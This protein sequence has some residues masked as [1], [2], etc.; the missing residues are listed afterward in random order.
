MDMRDFRRS[1]VFALLVLLVCCLA[2]ASCSSTKP[3]G[4]RQDPSSNELTGFWRPYLLYALVSPHPRLYVEV[5]AVEGCIPD[6]AKLNKL[7]DFLTTYCEKP[8]G[9]DIVRSDVIPRAAAQGIPARALARRFLNGPPENAAAPSPA[10]MYVLFYDQG[11]SDKTVP[12]T[13]QAHAKTPRHKRGLNKNP[14]VDLLPY[15][16]AIFINTRYGPKSVRNELL[17]HEAG[18]VLGVAGRPIYA[19][20]YHCLDRS[21]LMYKT[22]YVHIGR[23][24]LGRDPMTQRQIC[25]RCVAE[26]T[27]SQQQPA[28][29]KLR[30]V[31]PVLVRSE[32]GYH[33]LSLPFRVKLIVGDL[34]E[35]DCR[36]FAAAVRAEAPAPG[37][38]D[39]EFRVAGLVKEELFREPANDEVI[40]RAK[41][42]P[43]EAVRVA[44]PRIWA[45]SWAQR[46]YAH[47][48]FTN[49]VDI[50]RQ[51]TASNPKDDWSFNQLAWIRATC[52]DAS[53]RNGQEAV[54]AATKACE[55]TK[56]KDGNL[57]DTLAAACAESGDFKGAIRFEEQ[58][59]RTGNPTESDRKDMQARLSLYKQS[60][61]FREGK[62][63]DR[64]L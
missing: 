30:F 3:R 12:Q 18:H 10:F 9:I 13:A 39:D 64:R 48:Q 43:Y 23:L 26:L 4:A 34:S 42:D 60:Q 37:A 57:I 54:T 24:L 41:S 56:W 38:D 5:D 22:L 28:P 55:L 35:Q 61:P 8:R 63:A 50:Y 52:A 53:V 19:S 7:R 59:L 45:Q 47:G 31:G 20:G 33:V 29:Y 36:D 1:R 49:A 21:C 62:G 2:A 6:E 51:A 40:N 32:A 27:E 11:L 46:Y 17:V 15:P 16:S 44:A 14:H 58:A 25:P